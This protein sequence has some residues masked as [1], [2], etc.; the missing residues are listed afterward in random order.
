MV[1]GLDLVIGIIVP[2]HVM[3][4]QHAEIEHVVTQFL[5]MEEK[6]VSVKGES[7]KTATL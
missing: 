1:D 5:K 2:C 6:N 7:A 4:G 3:A